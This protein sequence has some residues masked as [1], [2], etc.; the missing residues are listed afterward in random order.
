MSCGI[1][2]PEMSPR[3]FSFNSPHGACPE[4]QGL[5]AVYDFDPARIVPD[6]TLSL[7]EGAIHPWARGDTRLVRE[8]LA[9]LG[10]NFGL[11]LHDTRSSG[12]RSEQ[13]DLLLFG[14][15]AA[16]NGRS[17]G[18]VPGPAGA[19]SARSRHA[20]DPYGA[21]FEGIVPNLRRRFEQ[22][23]WV[24]QADLDAYRSLRPCPACGGRSAEA[25]E[26]R[27]A[28]EGADRSPTTSTCRSATRLACSAASS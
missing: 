23:V 8:A 11:D 19:G 10:R 6:E 17:A 27:R 9:A 24:D 4:C 15:A 7:L 13:R 21:G 25:A 28:G 22:G 3:A 14:P 16:S 5:G 1:S 18:S 12:C 26:P 20:R 2:V